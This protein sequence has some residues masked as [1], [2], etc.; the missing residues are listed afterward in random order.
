M[1]ESP[2]EHFAR[3]QAAAKKRWEQLEADPGLAGPWWQLFRQVQS[4]RHVLSELLQNADDAKAKQVRVRLK[5]VQKGILFEFAHDGQDFDE[6]TL[7]SLCQFGLSNKR[8]LHTIGFR[9]IGFKSVFSLGDRVEV[10]TPTLAFKFE[11][12]RFTLP[13]WLSGAPETGGETIIRVPVDA[14]EKSETIRTEFKRWLESPIPLLFFSHIES[15][16]IENQIVRREVLQ[17]GPVPGS[18]HIR[19]TSE[20]A[21]EVLLITSE[22]ESFP[23]DAVIEIR[24]ERGSTEIDLPPC[25]VQIVASRTKIENRLYTVLPTNILPPV[26]FSLNAPFIQDP[27]RTGIKDLANSPTNRWLL[28]RVGRLAAHAI[29]SWLKDSKLGLSERAQA[30][31]LLPRWSDEDGDLDRTCA[32]RVV[33]ALKDAL[34]KDAKILLADDGTLG[35]PTDTAAMPQPILLTWGPRNAL[36][37]FSPEDK[38][39]LYRG[40]STSSVERLK[41]WDLVRDHDRKSIASRLLST[42]LPRPPL[43]EQVDN[44]VFLWEYLLPLTGPENRY[45]EFRNRIRSLAIVP[46]RGRGLLLPATDVLVLGGREGT[47]AEEDWELLVRNVDL[48]ANEW[49]D[50]LGQSTEGAESQRRRA[51]QD[52]YSRLQ[53]DRKVGLEQVIAAAAKTIFQRPDPSE[54]GIRIARI[55][56]FNTVRIRDEF[57]FLCCDGSWRPA[58][59]G[60]L[61]DP[62]GNLEEL[63]PPPMIELKLISFN[64][65]E[66]LSQTDAKAWTDW[67]I[68]TERSRLM[69][70]P[71]PSVTESRPWWY[72]SDVRAFCVERGGKAPISFPYERDHFVLRDIDWD[73]NLWTFWEERAKDNPSLWTHLLL[74]IL[75]GWS[76]RWEDI[77]TA[78]IDQEGNAYRLSLNHDRLR[79]NWVQRL[80]STTCL[81]DDRDRPALPA[82]VCRLTPDTQPLTN[83]ERFLDPRFDRPEYLGILDLL[84]VRSRPSGFGPLLDRLRSL[85]KVAS[86]P[87]TAIVDIYRALDRVL[88]HM[89]PDEARTLENALTEERLVYTSDGTWETLNSVFKAN[90]EIVPGV[91]TLYPG[92]RDLAMWDRIHLPEKPTVEMVLERLKTLPYGQTISAGDKERVRQILRVAP[93]LAWS[94]CKGWI[95]I[96]GCWRNVG[97]FRWAACGYRINGLLFDSLRQKTADL[98]LLGEVSEAFSVRVRLPILEV[99]IEQRLVTASPTGP[100]SKPP[101]LETLSAAFSRLR[102]S[103]T[104][105]SAGN[106]GADQN[107]RKQI[108]RLSQTHWQEVVDLKTQPYLDGQP[109]GHQTT[110]KVLWL[111]NMIYAAGRPETHYRE[112]VEELCRHF[113]SPRIRSA[114]SDCIGREADWITAYAE[115]H[116]DLDQRET[117]GIPDDGDL[118]TQQPGD[119]PG[120]VIEL[121]R[122]GKEIR[123]NNEEL[124][125]EPPEDQEKTKGPEQEPQSPKTHYGPTKKDAFRI[126]MERNG[127]TYSE[128]ING[129]QNG[130]RCIKANNDGAFRWVEYDGNGEEKA[131]YWLGHGSL[132]HGV[133]IPAEIWDTAMADIQLYILFIEGEHLTM[134]GLTQLR[135]MVEDGTASLYAPQYLV[136]TRDDGG[137][138]QATTE[139][140]GF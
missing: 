45:A 128:T 42:D 125:G 92:A 58:R 71:L 97:D 13:I 6:Q 14:S 51:A 70:F 99:V 29:M 23:Q 105:V 126:F 47:I 59:E 4:P 88:L 17:D 66:G 30:Y 133:E 80:A 28:D 15:L 109:A 85:S 21:L 118:Q 89:T 55:A 31:T 52:L 40:I 101:W 8:H 103:E 123:P 33:S 2:P 90:P 37:I 140:Q 26:P 36:E 134:Y 104:S 68:D 111:G 27:A 116:L 87:I 32:K 94:Q 61:F 19:V 84:G 9:G 93:D 135:R 76:K 75:R 35:A 136:K 102:L 79:A 22:P 138:L 82:E 46:V 39:A 96:S 41:S 108:S 38:N 44:L 5:E 20:Q 34:P 122:G 81:F 11:Q 115:G 54:D 124:M 120:V 113:H 83:I 12:K 114:I 78:R 110:R 24:D 49:E 130:N 62:S 106:D 77:L 73:Q 137:E 1:N 25:T 7:H 74:S 50:L 72:R 16:K 18:S 60:L 131:R 127:F 64:Y 121:N 107:D 43:P 3:V 67:A 132:T 56:A 139:I 48:V 57:R 10:L 95:D 112:V 63:L 65:I 119:E 69:A 86:P 117:I 98:S 129:Y 100:A 53:L 91:F